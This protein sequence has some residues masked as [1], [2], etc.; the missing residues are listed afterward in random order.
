MIQD[1]EDSRLFLAVVNDEQQYSIW[2]ADLALPHGWHTTGV[3]GRKADCLSHI[4]RTWIDQRPRSLRATS[5]Q[6]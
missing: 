1:A 6:P 4:E 2:P 3:S 5:G